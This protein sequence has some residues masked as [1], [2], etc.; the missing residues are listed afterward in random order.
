ME[1]SVSSGNVPVERALGR[2][3]GSSPEPLDRHTGVVHESGRWPNAATSRRPRWR[4]SYETDNDVGDR[5]EVGAG[6]K[7]LLAG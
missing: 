1:R 7:A 3:K 6:T 2:G 4:S 5:K